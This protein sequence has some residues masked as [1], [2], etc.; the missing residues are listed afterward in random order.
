VP[1]TLMPIVVVASDRITEDEEEGLRD[2]KSELVAE[3]RVL[4]H[5]KRYSSGSWVM[6]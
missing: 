2:Q 5:S 4:P 6:N 1:F 3:E